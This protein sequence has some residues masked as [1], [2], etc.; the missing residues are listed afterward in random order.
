[1]GQAPYQPNDN[2]GE[3]RDAERTVEDHHPVLF[4][5]FGRDIIPHAIGRIIRISNTAVPE[6]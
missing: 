1:M 4:G 3:D 6:L 2:H 5:A